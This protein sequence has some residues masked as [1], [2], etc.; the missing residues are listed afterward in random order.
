MRN[1]TQIDANAISGAIKVDEKEIQNHLS[2][3]VRQSVEE[4]LN[5]LLNAEADALCGASRYQRSPER[6]DTRAGSLFPQIDD[7]RWRS[8]FDDS[9]ASNLAV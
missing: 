2:S 1:V 9:E 8:R 3:L 5:E 4:T 7:A 6:Q